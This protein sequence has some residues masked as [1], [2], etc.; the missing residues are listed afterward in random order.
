[1]RL[2][3]LLIAAMTLIATAMT[4][5]EK[6]AYAVY[7][8]EGDTPTLYFLN[9]ETAF[10]VGG[11]YTTGEKITDVWSGDQV[12]SSPTKGN[13]PKW[14]SVVKGALKRVAFESTFAE[15]RPVSCYSWF[16]Y[17]TQLA[18]IE[19]IENLKTDNVTTMTQMF[20]DCSNLTQLDVSGFNTGNV[21]TMSNMFYRC[22][23]LTQLDVSGF[24]TE[25]VTDMSAMFSCCSGLTQL[26]VRGINTGEVT[27]MGLMFY[28]C[29]G[30]TQLD[31]SGFNTE[32]VT[33]MN[34]MFYGCSGLT[35]LDLSSFNTG[36]VTSVYDI[37]AGC[38]NL[39]VLDMR[40]ASLGYNIVALFSD[41][42]KRGMLLYLSDVKD[43]SEDNFAENYVVLPSKGTTSFARTFTAN[44][45]S[46]ICLPF[47]VDVTTVDGTFYKYS[48]IENDEV[49]FTAVTGSTE[50][51]TPYLFM[52]NTSGVT[53]FTGNPMLDGLPTDEGRAEVTGLNG[54][55]ATKEFSDSEV[56][57]GLYY[58]WA[59][60]SFWRAGMGSSVK[61]NRA[62]LKVAGTQGVN[63]AQ[64]M[65]RLDNGA[66]AV[67]N[68]TVTTDDPAAPVYNLNGQRVG[69]G[70]KGIVIKNGKKVGLPK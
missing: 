48:T 29:S 18:E 38:S 40:N 63:P 67:D 42:A 64:F 13:D 3:T 55:Y 49:K 31:V 50:A 11:T 17:C 4:A 51:D 8:G 1:M 25:K 68:I 53:V 62:Y 34:S 69:A 16:K 7:C 30:L 26:D 15:V 6:T 46:T 66:T 24:N 2:K 70:Y 47:A 43:F 19:G 57:S 28:R 22:S 20:S 65:V 56:S 45:M 5:Q 33:L 61:Q 36:E 12:T 41:F 35:Q 54:V 37:F 32:K 44:N 27:N 39:K 10:R 59:N 23:G 58:G 9:S 52:P 60:G 21:T 14:I